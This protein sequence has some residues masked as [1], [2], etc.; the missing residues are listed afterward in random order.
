VKEQIRQR[1]KSKLKLNNSD[2]PRI[3]PR[4]LFVS[5]I[6][7]A[8]VCIGVAFNNNTMFGNDPVGMFYDGIR[9]T[10][11]YT[12]AELGVASNYI[13]IGLILLLLVFGRRYV[14]IG[15]FLYLIPYGLLVSF[16]SHSYQILFDN[17]IFFHRIL[18]G[19]IGITLYYIGISL[20]V[21][22]NIGVDPFTGLMLTI[23]DKT[24]WSMRRAK[25]TMDLCLI[26]IGFLL[27]G[28]F[29]IITV[30]T[31]LTTGP[32]IQYLSQLFETKFFKKQTIH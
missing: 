30:I 25:V 3:T 13:N 16:G 8:F 18:G 5:I 9:S 21:A 7:I 1:V 28:K 17:D 4:K 11:Q 2:S 26:A 24:K 29:G 19:L 14:N 15:T 32:V 23:R 10:L 27:G 12:Q 20:F 6:G 31:A 22:S